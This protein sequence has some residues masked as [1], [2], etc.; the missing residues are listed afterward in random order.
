M[1]YTPINL[2]KTASGE[3]LTAHLT[4]VDQTIWLNGV[5]DRVVK[6]E[7]GSGAATIENS[8]L[9]C[10][11]GTTAVS[12]CVVINRRYAPYR[13]G[14]GL[15]CRFTAIFEPGSNGTQSRLGLASSTD[16]LSFGYQGPNFGIYYDNGGVQEIQE[17]QVTTPAAGAENATV[18][19]GG[20][21]Y[22]VPLTAGTVQH[23]A[24][25]IS[26]SLNTQVDVFA[27]SSNGDTVTCLFE[28]TNTIGAFAFSSATAT[29]TW[30]Q[31]K[32]SS[33]PTATF[34]PQSTWNRDTVPS[35]DVGKGNVY[36]I[37]T[38]ALS[39][40]AIDFSVEDQET[41]EFK[42]VHR[43]EYANTSTVPS[44]GSP[45]LRVASVVGNG[46]TTEDITLSSALAGMF[47][48][49]V[50]SFS[51]RPRSQSNTQT[52]I[53]ST[54][55]NILTIRNRLVFSEVENRIENQLLQL[56]SFTDSAKGALLEVRRNA[57]L[58]SGDFDYS[59]VDE[60]ESITEF[61]TGSNPVDTTSGDVILS[62]L[63]GPGSATVLNLQDLNLL[64]DPRDSV[65]ISMAVTSGAASDMSASIIFRE[66][67]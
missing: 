22:T 21:P 13:P 47:V 18:T 15:L 2:Q 55:T 12:A 30:T 62:V 65:T 63:V 56:T 59:Y 38:Q 50:I 48:E 14:L 5:T 24:Y 53:G 60:V 26:E 20:T 28:S 43:I 49:G 3:A 36:Q 9:N 32:A 1:S 4:P 66:N 10:S 61:D 8:M 6:F 41:G 19:I 44:L 33:P 31:I 46:F 64:L 11:T 54:Q 16:S 57:S 52:G 67:I 34:I 45:Y 29:G 37:R 7:S 58:T 25:E 23:N 27:F 51:E 35:L 39:F 42:L 40:G 17:L